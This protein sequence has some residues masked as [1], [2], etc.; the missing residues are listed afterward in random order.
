MKIDG[1]AI[2]S[3]VWLYDPGLT[4]MIG[5]AWR[6]PEGARK[7]LCERMTALRDVLIAVSKDLTRLKYF[8]WEGVQLAD[9]SV[10]STFYASC[11][12][13]KGI[14]AKVGSQ[15]A[16][17]SRELYTFTNLT[18]F[19]V[20]VGEITGTN[21]NWLIPQSELPTAFWT[22]ILTQCPTLEQLAISSKSPYRLA[23]NF[24]PIIRGHWPQLKSLTLGPFGFYSGGALGPSLHH[25]EEFV[26]FLV[27][28]INLEELN[29][30]WELRNPLEEGPPFVPFQKPLASDIL[31]NLKSFIGIWQQAEALPI[32][33]QLQVLRLT[34]EPLKECEFTNVARL[35]SRFPSLCS[36]EITVDG[37]NQKS[38]NSILLFKAIASSCPKLNE[39]G[40]ICREPEKDSLKP[41]LTELKPLKLLR[42]VS[43]TK[44]FKGR[45]S[46]A[47][48][49]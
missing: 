29:L 11:P 45:M 23:Y 40:L 16:S 25:D 2:G 7:L 18:R 41:L 36:L 22:L 10:W 44:G 14:S 6:I 21:E 13:L 12:E 30:L 1:T 15:G 33:A 24:S 20:I 47:A 19:S 39:F 43:L 4:T 3:E 49:R 8:G 26:S 9:D 42:R 32:L 27:K 17:I 48:L 31:L 38:T 37:V 46:D 34:C 28:H 5:H 35:I